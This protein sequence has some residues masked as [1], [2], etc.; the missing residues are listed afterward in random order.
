MPRTRPSSRASSRQHTWQQWWPDSGWVSATLS[1]AGGSHRRI[2][3]GQ[4]ATQNSRIHDKNIRAGGVPQHCLPVRRNHRVGHWKTRVVMMPA[5]VLTGG[6]G[7]SHGYNRRYQQWWQSWCHDNSRFSVM[8]GSPVQIVCQAKYVGL[9]WPALQKPVGLKKQP[10]C[11]DSNPD[12]GVSS[13]LTIHFI[14]Y[15]QTTFK[16]LIW[17]RKHV[18]LSTLLKQAWCMNAFISTFRATLYQRI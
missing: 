9:L 8:V 16:A 7:C 10:S 1:S 14:V 15:E 5:F 2:P 4:S 11:S 17:N 6:T 13:R 18:A 12:K 3:W